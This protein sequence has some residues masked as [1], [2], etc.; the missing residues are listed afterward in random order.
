[1]ADWFVHI[2]GTT[3]GPFPAAHVRQWLSERRLPGTALFWLDGGTTWLSLTE[4]W[5][6]LAADASTPGAGSAAASSPSAQGV[7]GAQGASPAA[8]SPAASPAGSGRPEPDPVDDAY[9]GQAPYTAPYTDTVNPPL[10]TR[11]ALAAFT[12]RLSDFAGVERIRGFSLSEL[13]SLAV[14]RHS[15]DEIE[16]NFA[17][18]I[19]GFVPPLDKVE[20]DWF[21]PWMFVRF[22][23]S[24]SL[25]FLAFV[26]MVK[27]FDNVNLLPGMIVVGSFVVPI[28]VLVFFFEANTPRNVSLYTVTHAFLIGGV[29]SLAITLVLVQFGAS[30]QP[31]SMPITVGVLEE[32]GKLLA[33]FL[34]TWRLP[35]RRYPWMLNGM[36]F[37]A[38]VGAGFAAFESAGYALNSLLS[39][40]RIDVD[41]SINVIFLRGALAP[42]GHVV[43]TALVGG[44]L[45][46]VKRDRMLRPSMLVDLR[47]LRI[48]AMV[49]GLHIV[50]DLDM[51]LP[52]LLKYALLG[53][54]AWVVVLGMI[55]SGLKQIKATQVSAAAG[56]PSVPMPTA[57]QPRVD[58]PIRSRVTDLREGRHTGPGRRSAGRSDGH[59]ST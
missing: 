25:L 4:A 41:S 26:A 18:G 11:G 5:P 14:Q 56:G 55:T 36:L 58:L 29:L 50:W 37:G 20:S 8:D 48:L 24:A 51:Q 42:F 9:P 23:T 39:S 17:T 54:L 28:A 59:S 30:R 45:W 31:I 3:T 21:K 38:A 43:W 10:V 40:G 6:V 32:V 7:Q 27:V 53:I 33:V 44:A 2:D 15:R 34:I 35:G 52:F 19:P 49:T 16:Q 57:A 13:F 47:V 1:M 46:R 12:D 22:Y